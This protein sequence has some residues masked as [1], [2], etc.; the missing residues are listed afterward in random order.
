MINQLKMGWNSDQYIII[1]TQDVDTTLK[2]LKMERLSKESLC[3]ET[4]LKKCMNNTDSDDSD[5]EDECCLQYNKIS[6]EVD[7]DIF[8]DCDGDQFLT[9]VPATM[10]I[11]TSCYKGGLETEC[12]DYFESLGC[13]INAYMMSDT[14]NYGTLSTYMTIGNHSGLFALD[15][16]HYIS[17]EPGDDLCFD[18]QSKQTISIPM[19]K[20][21]LEM[22]NP[23]MMGM[24]ERFVGPC[25]CQKNHI[26][27]ENN[28]SNN[29]YGCYEYE[30]GCLYCAWNYYLSE[31]YYKCIHGQLFTVHCNEIGIVTLRNDLNPQI[32]PITMK[33]YISEYDH[34]EEGIVCDPLQQVFLKELK[35]K[36]GIKKATFVLVQ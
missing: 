4:I 28:W 31:D 20:L 30:I 9:F 22:K 27:V 2:M 11:Y 33:G 24:I 23:P 13:D 17:L 10:S 34:N 6:I 8:T 12:I 16:K 19:N 15:N 29:S 36:Y 32:D 18:F 14:G 5:S 1:H 26:K 3:F 7:C 35:K 21:E 25:R